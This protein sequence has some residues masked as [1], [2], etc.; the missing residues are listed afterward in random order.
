MLHNIMLICECSEY[1]G[2]MVATN[3][4]TLLRCIIVFYILVTASQTVILSSNLS[5]D[6][7]AHPQQYI[8][9]NCVVSGSD[10]LEWRS[11]EYIGRGEDTLQLLAIDEIGTNVSNPNTK[12]V[13][14]LVNVSNENG[15]LIITS[16]L[17]LRASLLYPV[18][19]VSCSNNGHGSSK[20]ITFLT[21]GE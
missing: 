13:A 5:E 2:L 17:I 12:A 11:E 20:N 8:I 3:H 21:Q 7:I 6:H 10:I 16:R 9:F 19:T 15:I 18:S 14:K 1:I 4:L